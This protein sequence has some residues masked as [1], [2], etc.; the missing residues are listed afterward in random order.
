MKHP[1]PTE[2]AEYAKSINFALDGQKFYDYY[3]SV[4]WVV[5]K[6]KPMKN[7]QAAVRTWKHRQQVV[8]P[9]SCAVCHG[10]GIKYMTGQYGKKNWLCHECLIALNGKS[11]EG[12]ALGSIERA[13]EAGKLRPKPKQRDPAMDTSDKVNAQMKK[14]SE[15]M[16][17]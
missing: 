3:E 11:W 1:T 5:G 17:R 15:H 7:W 2:I 10:D 9:K 6:N 12:R 16:S 13:V 14:L 4:G 8:N